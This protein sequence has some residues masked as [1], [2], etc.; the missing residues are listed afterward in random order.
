MDANVILES[1]YYLA[2]K[3]NAPVDKLAA[4]KLLFFADRYHLRK[5][6][7]LISNDTYYALPHGPVP[8]NTLDIINCAMRGDTTGVAKQYIK[9]NQGNSFNAVEEDYELDY[10]SDSDIEALDFVMD[11]FSSLSTWALRDLTHEYPEWK[12]YKNTLESCESRR[13][14]I[15]MEDFFKDADIENDPFKIIPKRAVELSKEFYLG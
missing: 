3:S 8:S 4:I 10:L 13:E 5:Y 7:R 1:V 12:R 11:K 9:L 14:L 2:K 6:G 15:L